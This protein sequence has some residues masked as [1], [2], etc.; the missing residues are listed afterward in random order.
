MKINITT[1]KCRKGKLVHSVRI[2]NNLLTMLTM[3]RNIILG[4]DELILYLLD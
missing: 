1:I 3:V 2:V 4:F